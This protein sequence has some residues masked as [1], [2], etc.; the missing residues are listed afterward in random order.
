MK[1]ITLIAVIA[2]VL[3]QFSGVVP[4]SS[5]GGP[6]TLAMV[7][8]AAALA[9]GIYEAWSMRRGVLGWI[10]SILT[11]LAGAI[12]A[13]LAGGTLMDLFMGLIAPLIDLQG[14]LAET[15]HP[16][17]YITSAAMMLFILLGAWLALR[18]VNRWR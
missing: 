7:F 17:L 4:L 12:V 13:G 16:L 8:L 15:R 6:M 3:I 1:I 2:I 11:A 14:S 5:V 10:V 9:A 18:L